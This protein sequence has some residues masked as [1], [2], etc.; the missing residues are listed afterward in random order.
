MAQYLQTNGDY[1]I[2]TQ[3]GGDVT[4]DTGPGIGRLFVTGN[5]VVE[6]DTLTVEA[7]N[8]DV[9]DNIITLNKGETGPGITLRY[10]GLEIDRGTLDNASF[11]F[12]ENDDSFN[13]V[14]GSVEGG[15]IN[16]A[17]S[18]LRTRFIRTNAETDSG[19]LT[20]IGTGTGVVKVTGTLNYENQ[21]TQPDHIPN[22]KYVDDSIRDNPTFQIIDD[23]SRV[24]ITDKDVTG[25]LS[26]IEDE[27][28]FSTFGESAVSVIIDGN[29]YSQFYPNRAVIQDIEIAGN[30]V[31]NNDT[32][33]NIFLRTQGTGKLQTNYAI[34]LEEISNPPA[35][36]T[37]STI[38]HACTPDV[39][40]SGLFFVGSDAEEDELISKNRSLLLSMLF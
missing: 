27:T 19:D 32:N 35:S 21:V 2:K 4:I 37:G 11:Y 12:D 9:N 24:I 33:A 6:G 26:Y 28:G 7:E 20:L 25:A 30:E 38:I 17:S 31:T 8:L 34:Q 16:Y 23:N 18:A 39:G 22:K 10:S 5:L 29:L 13:F 1:T 14:T 36:V 3:E 40:G 15:V